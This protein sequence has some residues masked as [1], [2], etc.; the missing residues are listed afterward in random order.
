MTNARKIKQ[1]FLVL[2]VMMLVCLTGCG[3]SDTDMEAAMFHDGAGNYAFEP[4][5][6]ESS[7]ETV[8]DALGISSWEQNNTAGVKEVCMT[9]ESYSWDSVDTDM[10]CEF[11]DDSLDT[12]TFLIHPEAGEAQTVWESV[13]EQFLAECGNAELQTQTSTVELTQTEMVTDYYIWMGSDTNLQL[14]HVKANGE[15]KYIMLSAAQN[16]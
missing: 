9:S 10:I 1:K 12:V 6:W 7:R 16:P 4:L 15:T 13:S 14:S 5:G 2:L 8:E 11:T 3:A